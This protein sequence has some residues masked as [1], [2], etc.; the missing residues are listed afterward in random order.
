IK[1]YTPRY[2]IIFMD[3]K[4]YPYLK[5]EK[6]KYPSLKIVR[7]SKKD[8]KAK[9]FGPYPDVL[10]ARFTQKVLNEIY[11]LRKCKKIPNKV[12]LY[13]H[14]NQCLGPCVYPID[15]AV[16]TKMQDGVIRFLNGETQDVLT[17]LNQQME[18]Y[19]ETLAFE[20]AKEVHDRIL[21][22]QNTVSKQNVDFESLKNVDIFHY[23]LDKD[24]ISIQGLF[25]RN[26]K[27]LYKTSSILPI[28]AD[29]EE[30]V[31]SFLLQ[32]YQTHDIASELILPNTLID[33]GLEG[34]LE[35]KISYPVRTSKRH[36][37]LSMAYENAKIAHQ[38]RFENELRKNQNLDIAVNELNQ[39]FKRT[40]ERVELFDVSNISG[41]DNVSAMVVFDQGQPMKKYYRLFKLEDRQDDYAS[42][43]EVLYRRYFRLLKDKESLPSLLLVDGGKG[44]IQIAKQVM[45][46]LDLNI[47]IAGL[48]KN[49]QHKTTALLD[50]D[51]N[52]IALNKESQLFFLL[53]RMQDEVHR[54]A[55][56]YH[57]K[58]RS[59]RMQKSILDDVKGI[60]EVKKEKLFKHFKTISNIK[61]A[62][63][64]ELAKIVGK[65]AADSILITFS[66]K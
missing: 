66:Q 50:Q 26:G 11:P 30:E 39:I 27:L 49:E 10:S 53:T 12:C 29:A 41:Q 64:E 55:L 16:I 8:A 37:L 45:Q 51:L 63:R 23:Y 56:S 14:L 42:M 34:L 5:L 47:E 9:Y 21:A 15:D 48:V 38:E 46:A 60:G 58:L 17:F 59:K 20:K 13:Y 28:Y 22:I 35:S 18:Q 3:D 44:H 19:I 1:K 24:Y 57:T 54:F 43:Y 33:D 65:K 62:N 7:E 31:T 61:K 40:I 36:K 52:P 6:G 2:N 4:T 32:Y 25:V